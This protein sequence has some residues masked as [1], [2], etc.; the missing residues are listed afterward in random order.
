MSRKLNIA[1]KTVAVATALTAGFAGV[2]RADDS[3]MS[4]FGGDSY[5]Y[6]NRAPISSA[7]SAW[8]ASRPQGLSENAFEADSSEHL[9]SKL[10]FGATTATVS[11]VPSFRQTHPDGLTE[12]ELQ[13]LSSETSPWQLR[14]G[15]G[16]EGVA[17][18]L[19]PQGQNAPRNALAARLAAMFHGNAHADTSVTR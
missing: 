5:A 19:P 14:S 7:P 8:R 12:P 17:R 4:R 18:D 10:Q 11:S 6:F 15:T 9:A 3:S 1:I 2:A 13:A 16:S